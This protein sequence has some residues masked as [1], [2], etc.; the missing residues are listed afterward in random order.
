MGEWEPM[1]EQM[2]ASRYR[3]LTA[4]ARMLCGNEAEADDLVQDAIVATFG[5]LRKFEHVGQAEAYVRRAVVSRFIDAR[6]RDQSQR[7]A[8]RVIAEADT[9]SGASPD[10]LA[11][12]ATD[13]G[14]ALATLPPRQRACVVLRYIDHLST[15]EVAHTLNIS[16]GSV[17]RY[18][19]DGVARLAPLLGV[20]ADDHDPEWQEMTVTT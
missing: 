10:L 17:K 8:M 15:R 13:V 7:R 9:A 18:T 11:E 5:G 6:R 16:E 2:L 4:Y 20:P 3:A 14:R 1:L 19:A 12:H